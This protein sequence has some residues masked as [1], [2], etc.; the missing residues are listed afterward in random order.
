MTTQDA[1]NRLLW[2]ANN[3]FTT[4]DR[5]VATLQ[6]ALSR[7]LLSEEQRNQLRAVLAAREA[8]RAEALQA[9]EALKAQPRWA[10]ERQLQG[11]SK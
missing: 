4:A 7:S 9:L 11:E 3:R 10:L 8:E 1:V 6:A 2:K 5:S